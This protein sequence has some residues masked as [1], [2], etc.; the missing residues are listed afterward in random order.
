MEI[1]FY[2]IKFYKRPNTGWRISFCEIQNFNNGANWSLVCLD[3]S[4]EKLRI[5]F[6][7]C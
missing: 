1:E 7:G 3:K 4:P 6:Y 5:S 2:L